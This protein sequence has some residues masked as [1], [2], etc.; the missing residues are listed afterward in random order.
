MSFIPKI[1]LFI[2]LLG[3]AVACKNI[4]GGIVK[5]VLPDPVPYPQDDLQALRTEAQNISDQLD[6]FIQEWLAGKNN[7][8][9]PPELLPNGSVKEEW[10][11]VKLIKPEQL[12]PRDLWVIREAEE[13]NP[14]ALLGYYPDPHC[15]YLV[16]NVFYAPFGHTAVMEGEFPHSRYFSVQ[17]SPAFDPANYYYDGTFGVPEVPLVDIDIEP[18]SGHTN[19]FAPGANRRAQKRSYRL[20]FKL[21]A[22]DPVKLEPAYRPPHFLSKTNTRTVG[23]IQYQGPLAKRGVTGGHG[24]GVWNTGEF[25]VRYYAPDKAKGPL[26]GVPLPRVYFETPSGEKYAMVATQN[27][28]ET[29]LNTPWPAE[30][31]RQNTKPNLQVFGPSVGWFQALEIMNDGITGIH[32]NF[33]WTSAEEKERG[34]RQVLGFTSRGGDQPAPRSYVSS[35][36]REVHIQYFGRNITIAPG[37]VAVLTGKLP[38]TPETLSGESRMDKGQLRYF[39]VTT[40]P[41]PD[42]FTKGKP[43]G[44]ARSSVMDED[45]ITDA[46][47]NYVLVYSRPEDQP[48]NAKPA[49]KVTWVDRGQEA[50]QDHLIRMLHVHPDWKSSQLPFSRLTYAATSWLS[51]QYNNELLG[52]NGRSVL[53]A[54]LPTI[55][56]M[57]KEDFEQY[58]N[59]IKL[60]NT[61]PVWK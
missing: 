38:E 61:Q 39:S 42:W 51:P 60:S 13:V 54:Y 12:K 59:N 52:I 47:G 18:L 45:I 56:Y 35:T 30:Q 21:A 28:K 17:P 10:G 58:G 31:A 24:R 26:A 22:G 29:R 14:N 4:V 5:N 41:S 32:Q 8:I 2:L 3:T 7:G 43:F 23:A 1:G 6:A 37:Y 57:K 36:S 49:N 44:L 48:A 11:E 25:W 20:K 15:T 19:P 55:H 27:E 53:G 33:G 50:S 9:V 34:R 46:Q 40:Y 16:L